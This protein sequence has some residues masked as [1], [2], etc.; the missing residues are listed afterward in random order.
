MHKQA[1]AKPRDSFRPPAS[2]F[3][4][5]RNPDVAKEGLRMLSDSFRPPRPKS[6]AVSTAP[7]EQR[8][9]QFTDALLRS[10]H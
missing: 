9:Q 1:P 3:E 2:N 10:S 7:Y 6:G 8:L 4:A 5:L